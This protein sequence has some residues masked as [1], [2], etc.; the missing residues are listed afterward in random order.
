MLEP[1]KIIIGAL[2]AVFIGVSKA[3]FGGGLGM[4]TTPLCV[5]AFGPKEALGIVLPMLC[6]GDLFSLIHYW[7]KWKK[8]N[9]WYLLPGVV[10]GVLIGVRLI[11]RFS[12]R[13]LNV[14]IGSLAVGFVIF[15]LL[16]ETIFRAEGKFSPRFGLGFLFGTATGVAST[17]AHGAG[18]VVAMFLIPQRLPKIVFVG[19]T[20]L[21]FTWVNWIKMPFFLLD[22]SVIPLSWLPAKSIING[23]TIRWSLA[24]IPLVPAGVW[25]GVQLNRRFSETW[26]TRAIY[27]LL[28]LT[29]LQ[30][31]FEFDLAG[32]LHALIRAS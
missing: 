23:Q 10:A 6:A 7:G 5:L 21:I 22:Q 24:L 13:Q 17:F 8:E 29:G 31:I 20:V 2:A 30:L 11:G 28:F 14:A 1:G 26:F 25:L 27:A 18:P 15:Q 19:T 9:L 12:A 16:R 32:W 4:L 3:G